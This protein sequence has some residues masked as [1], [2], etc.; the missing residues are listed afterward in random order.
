MTNC[1]QLKR[2]GHGWAL[3]LDLEILQQCLILVL[4]REAGV[5]EKTVYVAPFA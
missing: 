4:G 5:G 2:P 1:H 3:E